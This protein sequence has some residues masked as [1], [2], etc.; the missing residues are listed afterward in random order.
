MR[1]PYYR[2]VVKTSSG[3]VLIDTRHT[4]DGYYETMVFR[5]NED[6]NIVREEDWLE[7]DGDRYPSAA[8]MCD[9][10]KRMIDKWQA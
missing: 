7:L 6:G 3:Y 1:E 8:E 10:H 9:G 5:C 2:D 4:F